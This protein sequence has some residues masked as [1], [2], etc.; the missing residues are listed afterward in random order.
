M[1]STAPT[2]RAPMDREVAVKTLHEFADPLALELFYKECTRAQVDQPSRTSSRSSTWASSRRAGS[3]RPVLRH[4]AAARA[5]ARR[6]D[7]QGQPSPHRRPRR[8]DHRADLPRPAGGAR[9]RS[10]PS[11]SQAEQH[12]RDGR[13][14]GEDH[15]LRRGARGARAS[16]RTTGFD[17]GTLLYMAPE[18]MQHKPVSVQSDIYSLGVTLY[19][20]LTR[21]QPFRSATEDAVIQA[22]LNAHSAAGLG[23]Q[24]GGQPRHQPRR[25][26]GDGQAAVEPLRHGA[27]VRRDAA[28]GAAQRADRDLR[29]GAHAAAHPD[30]DQGAR[31]GR[32]PVRG[33]DHLG[34]RG[35]GQHRPADRAAARGR[36]TR[37]RGRRPSR[38]CSRARGR[39]TRRKRIRWRCRRCRRSCSSIPPT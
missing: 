14:L 18:Q 31:E 23:P 9:A 32:L 5:D 39:G 2:I 10:G 33:R 37:S 19:E 3:K 25:A 4:A 8:R 26:Q 13:R 11:R 7:P 34:A 17:K 21:R 22:I 27:R 20:A 6:A 28:E 36:S 12:L 16:S 24:S 15:R 30:R 35:R 1:S 38:S 29:S